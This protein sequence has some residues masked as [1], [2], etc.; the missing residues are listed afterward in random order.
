VRP[1]AAAGGGALAASA[2]WNIANVGAVATTVSH[3]YGVSLAVVGL[4]T[5]ALFVT[6]TTVQIPA[7]R[8]CDRVGARVTGLAALAV[9]CIASA[10]ALAWRDAAYAIGMRMLAGVGTGLAFVAGSD[11]VRATAG[12]ALAQG[13]YGATSMAAGGLALALV[14][15]WGTWQAPF[16]TAAIV[17][18]A[19]IVLLATAPPDVRRRLHPEAR[20]SLFDRRLLPFAVMSLASFGAAVLVGNW[21]VT[22]LERNGH[23]STTVAGVAGALVL[24]LGIVTRP[25]GARVHQNRNACAR[26]SSPALSERRPSPSPLRSRSSFRRRRWSGSLQAFPSPRRSRER[27]ARARTRRPRRSA[28]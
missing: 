25:L 15:L 16:G 22:L 3:A 21:V 28:S 1:R 17:A 7:G 14:P 18:G 19:G 6:H 4:F 24:L 5:T 8:L 20:A 23:D 26:A 10:A 12:S 27:R 9:T 2:G 11:Y 13:F